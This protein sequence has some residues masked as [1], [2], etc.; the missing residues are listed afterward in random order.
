MI[1]R[2]VCCIG[3]NAGVLHDKLRKLRFA[4]I[5]LTWG[6]GGKGGQSKQIPH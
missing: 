4:S 3:F 6:G 2:Y 1:R 5:S